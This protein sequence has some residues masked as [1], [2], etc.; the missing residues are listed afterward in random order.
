VER[1][2]EILIT[3]R[4]KPV[5]VLRPYRPLMTREREKA[6]PHAIDVMEQGLPWGR[7]LRRFRREE[8]HER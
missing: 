5:A 1:G 2:E 8:M 7:T 6:I 4:N 3:N